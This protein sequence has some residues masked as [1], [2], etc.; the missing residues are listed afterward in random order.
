M[1]LNFPDVKPSRLKVE[2]QSPSLVS[3]TPS[4]RNVKQE[5]AEND[6]NQSDNQY[7]L[8]REEENFL[9]AWDDDEDMTD[10]EELEEMPVNIQDPA[11]TC[12]NVEPDPLDLDCENLAVGKKPMDGGPCEKGSGGVGPNRKAKPYS[13]R[14]CIKRFH[15]NHRRDLHEQTHLMPP[16]C[17]VC[18]KFFTSL[19]CLSKHMRIHTRNKSYK[20]DI[21][22]KCF[23]Q[24]GHLSDHKRV[25]TGEKPFKCFC[26]KVFRTSANWRKHERQVHKRKSG[27]GT[28][29]SQDVQIFVE[30]H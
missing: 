27:T 11:P 24:S 2:L 20:C 3:S 14:F 12:D 28:T 25:H 15:F 16:Q 30:N 18:S 9:A 1:H 4:S 10:E 17:S 23:T 19:G 6:Q 22:N 26:N 7:E 13:C 21:C 8:S 29:R 5:V